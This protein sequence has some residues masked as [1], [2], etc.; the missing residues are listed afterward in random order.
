MVATTADSAVAY[1][2]TP[3]AELLGRVRRHLGYLARLLD[4]RKTF[5]EHRRLLVAGGWLSLLAA[6]SAPSQSRLLLDSM[7]PSETVRT[8]RFSLY[9]HFCFTLRGFGIVPDP[10]QAAGLLGL[11]RCRQRVPSCLT[12]TRALQTGHTPVSG[13]GFPYKYGCLMLICLPNRG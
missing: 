4:A 3:P 2:G 8:L 11:R 10:V 9:G 13:A 7:A 1:P 5:D 12:L 6:T